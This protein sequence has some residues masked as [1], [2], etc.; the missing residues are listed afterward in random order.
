MTASHGAVV[1]CFT[2]PLRSRWFFLRIWH[3]QGQYE[4]LKTVFFLLFCTSHYVDVLKKRQWVRVSAVNGNAD[5]HVLRFQLPALD[6]PTGI[7]K[8]PSI[9]KR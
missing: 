3:A 2:T 6:F 1:N 5:C 4:I 8:L 7:I 9:Q